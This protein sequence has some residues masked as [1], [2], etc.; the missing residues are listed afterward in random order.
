MMKAE[1][2][3]LIPRRPTENLRAFNYCIQIQYFLC[4]FH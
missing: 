2:G 4:L 1:A 3:R